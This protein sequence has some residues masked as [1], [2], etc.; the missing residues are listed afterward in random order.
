VPGHGKSS[1]QPKVWDFTDF[2]EFINGFLKA[3]NLKDITLIGHSFGGGISFNIASINPEVRKMVLAAPAGLNPKKSIPKFL[4][5]F[6]IWGNFINIF[7]TGFRGRKVL[8]KDALDAGQSLIRNL[9]YFPRLYRT[10]KC[11]GLK[12]YSEIFEKINIPTLIVWSDKD[13]LFPVQLGHKFQKK[14][15]GSK[16]VLV[17]GYHKWTKL[18]PKK[19]FEIIKDFI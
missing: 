10:I 4:Y 9:L 19:Y 3:K 11:A 5:D 16:L 14:I 8:L 12:D 15:K 1:I 6:F 2:A 7:K 13:E 18:Y 17:D